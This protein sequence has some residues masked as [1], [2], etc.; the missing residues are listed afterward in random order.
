M[1]EVYNTNC[2]TLNFL[3]PALSFM[4]PSKNKKKILQFCYSQTITY[5]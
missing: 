1:L 3:F 5:N 4:V 2:L